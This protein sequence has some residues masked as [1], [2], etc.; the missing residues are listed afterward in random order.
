MIY[1]RNESSIRETV[2]KEKKTG[3]SFAFTSAAKAMATVHSHCLVKMERR[4]IGR[5]NFETDAPHAL[6]FY[7][8]AWF[9]LFY[10]V[11]NVINLLLC[12]IYK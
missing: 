7:Y 8:H 10:F 2:Q 3:A 11:I 5:S 6:K 12:L 4:Y 1:C 9:K